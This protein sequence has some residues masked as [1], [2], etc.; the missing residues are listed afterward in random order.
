MGPMRGEFGVFARKAGA[1][2]WFVTGLALAAA[3]PALAE[4]ALHKAARAGNL[5]EVQKLL[6]SARTSIHPGRARPRCITRP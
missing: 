3:P 2:A 5:A 4:S 1:F 6:D